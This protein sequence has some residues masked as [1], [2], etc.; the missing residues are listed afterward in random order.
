MLIL[1]GFL[2]SLFFSLVLKYSSNSTKYFDI[3]IKALYIVSTLSFISISILI[4]M[5]GHLVLIILSVI[6][7]GIGAFG[8]QPFTCNA[9]EKLG[10]P[11]QESVSV[12]GF[13]FL[14]NVLGL[15][16]AFLS[17]LPGLLFF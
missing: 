17:T 11:V 6:F 12:N 16:L 13:Y 7:L 2:S 10:F 15:P 14:T 5:K 3:I 8:L 9:L 4:P 1:S